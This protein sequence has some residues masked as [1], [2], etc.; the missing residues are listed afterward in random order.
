M[1]FSK[2]FEKKMDFDKE[3]FQNRLDE[4]IEVIAKNRSVVAKRALKTI[5]DRKICIRSF[6]DLSKEHYLSIK[7]LLEKHQVF[8][9]DTYPPDCNAVFKIEN[10]LNGCFF[11]KN[12]IYLK[13]GRSA[14][15]MA[16]TLVHEISHY[17]Y[18]CMPIEKKTKYLPY[19]Q[20]NDEVMAFTAQKLFQK[21]GRCL[22]RN[23]VKEIHH[24]LLNYYPHIDANNKPLRASYVSGYYDDWQSWQESMVQDEAEPEVRNSVYAGM[25][26]TLF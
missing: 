23:D 20:Y 24:V 7:K 10:Q 18:K 19:N 25:A 8:L 16:G 12:Y 3:S 26:C 9:P 14:E 17:F 1:Y 2:F 11:F 5:K 15:A 6:F 22:L 13:S 21:N 4:A